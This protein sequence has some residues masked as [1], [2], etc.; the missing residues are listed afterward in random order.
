MRGKSVASNHRF[1]K[2]RNPFRKFARRDNFHALKIFQSQQVFVARDQTIAI[3]IERC[4]H[5]VVIIRIAANFGR[6]PFD[7]DGFG[8]SAHKCRQQMRVAGMKAE[9]GPELFFDFTE[10][11]GRGEHL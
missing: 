4:R 6:C 9:F 2:G 5:N 7:R 11:V 10:D 8:L 1:S 3:G